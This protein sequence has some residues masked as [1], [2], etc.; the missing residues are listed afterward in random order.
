MGKYNFYYDDN[1]NDRN[2]VKI[3]D[4]NLG[5]IVIYSEFSQRE[6]ESYTPREIMLLEKSAALCEKSVEFAGE[7]LPAIEAVAYSHQFAA[8]RA[9]LENAKAIR[10]LIKDKSAINAMI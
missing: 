9:R 5:D 8:N 6:E 7:G 3:P 10:A 1:D 4:L 2:C